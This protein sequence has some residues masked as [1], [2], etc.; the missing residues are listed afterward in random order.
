[1]TFHGL[2]DKNDEVVDVSDVGSKIHHMADAIVTVHKQHAFN[3]DESILLIALLAFS[4]RS[5]N[6]ADAAA[7][8]RLHTSPMLMVSKDVLSSYARRYVPKTAVSA[9]SHVGSDI[10]RRNRM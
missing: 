9:D 8:A 5:M 6:I 10:F 3:D 1:M 4:S 7:A 2:I